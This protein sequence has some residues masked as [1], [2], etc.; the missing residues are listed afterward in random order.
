[1]RLRELFAEEKRRAN[2]GANGN[3]A[4]TVVI[5]V[6]LEGRVVRTRETAYRVPVTETLFERIEGVLGRKGCWELVGPEG[7]KMGE[8]ERRWGGG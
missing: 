3:G 5:E 6:R 2:G 4:A 1:M 8:V 7:P